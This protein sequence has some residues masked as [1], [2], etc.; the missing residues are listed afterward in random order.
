MGG[1]QQRRR[2]RDVHVEPGVLWVRRYPL[3][4]DTV[5]ELLRIPVIDDVHRRVAK[6]VPDRLDDV[7]GV[8]VVRAKR[9]G[10]ERRRFGGDQVDVEGILSPDVLPDVQVLPGRDEAQVDDEVVT[11]ADV[12]LFCIPDRV[13]VDPLKYVCQ[14]DLVRVGL[15]DPTRL[16]RRH[17]ETHDGLVLL[18]PLEAIE[19]LF[20]RRLVMRLLCSPPRLEHHLA[21]LR[22]KRVHRRTLA[23]DHPMHRPNVLHLPPRAHPK[24]LRLQEPPR[25]GHK[26]IALVEQVV[27][28]RPQVVRGERVRLAEEHRRR[29]ARGGLAPRRAVRM[30]DAL[31]ERRRAREL[32][33]LVA[34]VLEPLVERPQARE[35]VYARRHFRLRLRLLPDPALVRELLGHEAGDLKRDVVFVVCPHFAVG[36]EAV[37]VP[38]PLVQEGEEHHAVHR[39]AGSAYLR[40]SLATER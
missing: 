24:H 33:D 23:E 28:H 15:D 38:L 32:G 26:Q 37:D 4:R 29:A 18:C 30:C 2:V 34:V 11:D 25:V 21:R 19:G 9:S 8:E 31:V 20:R 40:Y 13:Q 7:V 6:V 10:E 14:R 12:V 22:D 27:L 3:Y 35:H 17:E 16:H 39:R 5:V 36:H 1:G